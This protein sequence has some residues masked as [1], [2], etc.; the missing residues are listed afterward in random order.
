ME[1]E[2]YVVL[3][4]HM[5][6]VHREQPLSCL[7]LAVV[8]SLIPMHVPRRGTSLI[9]QTGKQPAPDL[10]HC[11]RSHRERRREGGRHYQLITVHQARLTL[12]LRVRTCVTSRSGRLGTT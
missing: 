10:I 3:T 4:Y 5:S 2:F 6:P 12:L 11:I 8:H 1:Y 7:W 9:I